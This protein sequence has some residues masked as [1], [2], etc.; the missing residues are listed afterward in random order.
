[1]RYGLVCLLLL[2]SHPAAAQSPDTL[3][4]PTP[5]GVL[6]RSLVLPGWGQWANGRPFKALVFGGAAAGFLGK[7]AVE[8]RDL[9]RAADQ[10]RDDEE[11][12]DRAARRN[13]WVLCLLAT[14]TLAGLD[15]YVDAHLADFEVAARIRAGPEM[16]LLEVRISSW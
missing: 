11:L 13:T 1:M 7:A 5:R 16:A 15:A 8:Q 3:N 9:G 12:Q 14:S 4:T 6:L 2:S 10:G